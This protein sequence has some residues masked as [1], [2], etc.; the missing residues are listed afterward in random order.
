MVLQEPV[1]QQAQQPHLQAPLTQLPQSQLETVALQP[2][3]QPERLDHH[4]LQRAALLLL[5]LP[6]A[7]PLFVQKI[8]LQLAQYLSRLNK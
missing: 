5:K 2:Q 3:T 6:L 7:A 8:R 1:E 4:L